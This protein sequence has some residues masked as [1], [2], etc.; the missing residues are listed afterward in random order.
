MVVPGVWLHPRPS[1]WGARDTLPTP[2]SRSESKTTCWGAIC[3]VLFVTPVDSNCDFTKQT[4]Q[5]TENSAPM[6]SIEGHNHSEY[7]I[8]P[9]TV[10]TTPSC[11]INGVRLVLKARKHFSCFF[12]SCV[13]LSETSDKDTRGSPGYSND[14]PSHQNI[15]AQRSITYASRIPRSF[16]GN[17]NFGTLLMVM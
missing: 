2:Q 9:T 3:V 8:A 4:T 15:A 16:V 5:Q 1:L 7:L 13:Q 11:M 12:L 17:N 6:R 10:L 14:I